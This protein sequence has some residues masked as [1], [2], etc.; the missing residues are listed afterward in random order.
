[1]TH[2]RISAP[3]ASGMNPASSLA[4]TVDDLVFSCRVARVLRSR[5][6]D[7]AHYARRASLANT[8]VTALTLVQRCDG[9]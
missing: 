4:D 8:D 7:L 3:A 9:L 2:G 5:L 6:P 1:M